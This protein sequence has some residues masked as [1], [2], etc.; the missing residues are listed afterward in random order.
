M[1]TLAVGGQITGVYNP[2][3]NMA[4]GG[5][6]WSGA[7]P[8]VFFAKRIDNSRLVK[9]ADPQRAREIRFL[10]VAGAIFF[11]V[12][13][14]YSFQHF[15]AIESSYK[16]EALRLQR[17]RLVEQNRELNLQEAALRDPQRIDALARKMGL[18]APR[19]SQFVN[20]DLVPENAGAVYA[21]ALPAPAMPVR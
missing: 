19:P 14:A 21:R 16:L 15:R 7:T 13:L 1:A 4:R 11:V 2:D 3:R 17:D 12:F 10:S 20:L 6:L 18:E 9:L 5:S 8:E